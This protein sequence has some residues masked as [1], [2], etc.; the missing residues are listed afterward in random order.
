MAHS[1][2]PFHNRF[3]TNEADWLTFGP[4]LR[5]TVFYA[6]P[7]VLGVLA[8]WRKVT[9]TS[10]AGQLLGGG[11]AVFSALFF[12]VLI[13]LAEIWKKAKNESDDDNETF[14]EF[15]G[16]A[17]A[18]VKVGL[19]IAGTCFIALLS[20]AMIDRKSSPPPNPDVL[21]QLS[22]LSITLIALFVEMVMTTIKDTLTAY[23][24]H[25]KPADQGKAPTN[26]TG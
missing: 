21:I 16:Y 4:T 19:V 9:L 7:I 6:T 1:L 12:A 26:P 18:T 25:P 8:L 20:L 10:D 2:P 15:I 3:K 5:L 11:V 24:V 22:A 13:P 14:A 23:T 17:L